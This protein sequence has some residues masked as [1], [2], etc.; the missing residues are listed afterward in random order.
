MFRAFQSCSGSQMRAADIMTRKV[1]T[2]RPD[3]NVRHAAR[4]MLANRIGG[5]PVCDEGGNLVGMLTEGDLL[6][7]SELGSA[8]LMGSSGSAPQPYPYPYSKGHGWRVGDAMTS[9]AVTVDADASVAHIAA[10]METRSIKRIPVVH[11]SRLVGIVSRRDIL[12]AI[13][14]AR[15]DRPATS[16]EAM[17]RAVLARLSS[18]LGIEQGAIE[19]RVEG[20][21]VA[22]CGSVESGVKRLAARV[23]AEAVCGL[24]CVRNEIRIANEADCAPPGS[25]R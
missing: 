25:L 10:L 9:G 3:D 8:A 20:G 14:A 17:K 13:V 24:G 7:R 6:H 12:E 11:Q 23:A 22:L 19:V 15:P 16:D 21:V 5:L 18:D 4:M 1:I 2:V